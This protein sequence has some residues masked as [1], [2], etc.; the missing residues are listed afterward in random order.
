MERE[1]GRDR[2][3]WQVLG[4]EAGLGRRWERKPDLSQDLSGDEPLVASAEMNGGSLCLEERPFAA[5]GRQQVAL[6]VRMT[7]SR[8]MLCSVDLS[9]V[10]QA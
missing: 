10:R 2:D 1:D 6:M 5:M 4:C 9:G 3:R 7:A 8:P